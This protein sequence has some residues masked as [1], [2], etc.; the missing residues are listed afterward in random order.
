[1]VWLGLGQY[2]FL[3]QLGHFFFFFVFDFIGLMC[4]VLFMCWPTLIFLE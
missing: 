4:Y 3:C 1:M 2:L